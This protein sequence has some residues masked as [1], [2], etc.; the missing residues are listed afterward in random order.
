[1]TLKLLRVITPSGDKKKLSR[2]MAKTYMPSAV[3]KSWYEWW[4]KSNFF[5]ADPDSSKPPFVIVRVLKIYTSL[6][7][8]NCISV[9]FVCLNALTLCVLHCGIRT[10]DL[11]FGL[12]LIPC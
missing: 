4:E 11:S 5:E 9:W 8:L 2:Q 3:E 1:M 7:S 6:D 12:T 10:Q